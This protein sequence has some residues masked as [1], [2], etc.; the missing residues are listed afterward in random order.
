M[1]TS[2][3]KMVEWN[4][5]CSDMS[6]STAAK[7]IVDAVDHQARSAQAVAAAAPVAVSPVRSC[8]RDQAV[9]K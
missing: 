1:A 6:Q 5:G 4:A 2:G 3:P 7:C 8:R 9:R